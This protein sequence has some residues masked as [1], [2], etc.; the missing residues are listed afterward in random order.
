MV[1]AIT[2][3]AR[4]GAADD[5]DDDDALDIDFSV[6][7]SGRTVAH[8]AD[9]MDVSLTT[10]GRMV[11]PML[12]LTEDER[13]ELVK[14]FAPNKPAEQQLL[15]HTPATKQ[16]YQVPLN[17]TIQGAARA[18]P[19][20][21]P[22]NNYQQQSQQYHPQPSS[23]ASSQGSSGSAFLSSVLNPTAT[24]F[25]NSHLSHTPPTAL[26]TSYEASHFG[27]RA[28]AGSISGRLRSA[29]EYLEEKGLLDRETKGI[30]KDLIIIGDEELQQAIDRYEGG[31]PSVL[32]EM[33]SSGA[34]QNRLPKDIDILGDLDLDFLTM[35]DGMAGQDD[36]EIEPLRNDVAQAVASKGDAQVQSSAKA[37]NPMHAGFP[38]LNGPNQVSPAYDDGIG[39]LEFAGDFVSDQA[40]FMQMPHQTFSN[41]N[42]AAASPAEANTMNDYDRRMRS[43]S[44]FSA[45]LNDPRGRTTTAGADG[46]NAQYGQ[47]MDTNNRAHPGAPA[48]AGINIHKA[49]RR[50]SAP[51]LQS[52]LGASL[53][54]YQ[55]E[56]QVL[57]KEEQ[58]RRDKKEKKE[59]KEKEKQERK[60]K[61]ELAKKKAA[62]DEME[63]HVPGSGRPRALSDPNLTT[64]LDQHGLMEVDRPDGWVG[65]YSAESRKARIDRFMEKRNH[66]V[67]TKTVKYDVRKNFADSRLRVKGRFVKKEDELL[68][69]ELMSLT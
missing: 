58:K 3:S 41:Q 18:I 27:K 7:E 49:N 67:W 32:E 19:V 2:G 42:S 40:N 12:G 10:S 17:G 6:T 45:L 15:P 5:D 39:D 51:K 36:G 47:W 60:E 52:G 23:Q 21:A 22:N 14:S 48:P 16:T 4:S 69:R 31:D 64:T 28:R 24:T 1:D 33:I 68:M 8:L 37:I 65:A 11:D 20:P 59:R 13:E 34:L 63:V 9:E 30:L 66:R 50:A 26:G 43:N 38:G 35:D 29:S 57:S 62:E 61:K 44:L 55:G 54:Q 53:E 25:G 46:Q 56:S